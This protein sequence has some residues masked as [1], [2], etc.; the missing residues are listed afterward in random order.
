MQGADV[1]LQSSDLISFRVHKSTMAI[2]SPFF[3]DLFSLPQPPDG[4]AI[5]ELPV[6]R[7]SEDAEV[8]HSLL[9]LLY[10]I[11]SV[12]PDSYEKA[13]ALLSAS[14]KYNMDT[15]SSAIRCKINLPTTEAAFRAY[16]I[17]SSKQ[18]IPEMENA[19]CLTV[20]HPMT[21]EI[22]ADALPLFEGSALQ[23]LVCFRKRCHNNLLSFFVDFVDGDENLSSAWNKCRKTERPS[24]SLQ[25]NKGVLAGWFRDLVTKHTKSLQETYTGS[26]PNPSSLHKEFTLALRAHISGTQCTSCSNLYAME[27]EALR[28][29]WLCRVS[30][31]RN[32][33]PF[34]LGTGHQTHQKITTLDSG[35]DA[36]ADDSPT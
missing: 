9:T 18:L 6:V 19:A 35:R 34:R 20:D 27:G 36:D 21:F 8:L 1:I 22:I 28:D 11:P 4:E 2:S 23:D 31:A 10:P 17:A 26:L 12:I 15:V 3:S 14:Q 5:D 13:L 7:L 29:K 24:P 25:S 33:E 16:A 30:D 32:R